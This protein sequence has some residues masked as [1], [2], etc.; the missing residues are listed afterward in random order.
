VHRWRHGTCDYHRARLARPPDRVKHFSLSKGLATLLVVSLGVAS[1]APQED[2]QANSLNYLAS[3]FSQAASGARDDALCHGL[4]LLKHNNFSC[5]QM[6]DYA[7]SVDPERR[8]V[9]RFAAKDCFEKVCGVFYELG[10][11]GF[12]LSG[13]EVEETA[14]LKQDEGKLRVYWYRNNMMYSGQQTEEEQKEE[15]DPEQIA[16]DALTALHPSLYAYPPCYG[17]RPS[18]NNLAGELFKSNEADVSQIE[19]WAKACPEVFCFALVGQKIAP[20]CPQNR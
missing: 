18:S 6:L 17:V 19:G 2:P 1:C 14:V 4:G 16:Y 7:A 13:N 20:L 5:S 3:W 15:K 9:T 12:D 8:Q 10:F 11:S